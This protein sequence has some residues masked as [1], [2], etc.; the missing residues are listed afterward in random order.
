MAVDL[1]ENEVILRILRICVWLFMRKFLDKLISNLSF[2][3]KSTTPLAHLNHSFEFNTPKESRSF[4][5][6]V[7]GRIIDEEKVRNIFWKFI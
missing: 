3:R 7:K 4:F 6:S 2:L 1:S 5:Q